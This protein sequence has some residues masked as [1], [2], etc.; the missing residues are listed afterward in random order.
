MRGSG[1]VM[2]R[3]VVEFEVWARLIEALGLGEGRHEAMIWKVGG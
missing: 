2:G 1:V 3:R